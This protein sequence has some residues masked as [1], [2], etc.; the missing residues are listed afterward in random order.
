MVINNKIAVALILAVAL[1]T[2]FFSYRRTV[3]PE[4]RGILDRPT[5][6]GERSAPGRTPG[7]DGLIPYFPSR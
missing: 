4:P 5:R 2:G 6:S 1:I 3:P 7:A